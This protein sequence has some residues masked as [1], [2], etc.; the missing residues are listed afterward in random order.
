M[1]FYN[2]RECSS[3]STTANILNLLAKVDIVPNIVY[4]QADNNNNL[5]IF[6]CSVFL[7]DGLFFSN[8][9]ALTQSQATTCGLAELMERLQNFSCKNPVDEREF[10]LK[11]Y[12]MSKKTLKFAQN[13]KKT[14]GIF[15]ANYVEEV[16]EDKILKDF[17]NSKS[18][19]CIEYYSVNKKDLVYIPNCFKKHSNGMCAGNTAEEAIVEGISE[20][21]ERYALL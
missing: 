13:V 18:I 6:Y 14:I 12:K 4:K 20:I 8:G 7:E 9:K 10:S 19:K 21:L 5:N 3:I 17:Y 15:A 1:D 2:R 16:T 11:E